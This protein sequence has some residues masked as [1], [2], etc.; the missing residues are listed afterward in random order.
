MN[1]LEP[2]IRR[3]IAAAICTMLV[4]TACSADSD[5]ADDDAVATSEDA[6]SDTAEETGDTESDPPGDA[7]EP[8]GDGGLITA[9]ECATRGEEGS[10]SLGEVT[11][12]GM[13][14]SVSAPMIAY[15]QE[16]GLL[17]AYGIDLEVVENTNPTTMYQEFVSGRYDVNLGDP[18]AHAAMAADGAPIRVLG[19]FNANLTW[20]VGTEDM[21]WTGPESLAGR[22]VAVLQGAGG[23]LLIRAALRQFHD[24]DIEEEAETVGA[25]SPPDA[26]SQVMAGA[27]DVGASFEVSISNAIVTNPEAGLVP[28][29][30]PNEDFAEFTDGETPWQ[31]VLSFRDD[32][33]A[34]ADTVQ[35]LFLAFQEAAE[36]LNDDV[37][38]LDRLA[39][40]HIGVEEGVYREAVESGRYVYDVRPMGEDIANDIRAMLEMRE[41]DDSYQGGEVPDSFYEGLTG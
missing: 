24:F 11:F 10:V 7:A 39:V 25:Q 1:L 21:E 20:L 15:A 16:N 8:D 33:G 17:D 22:R 2:N 14:R 18:I 27:A 13:Q 32:Q 19:G 5:T 34:D 36:A 35:C 28:V 26:L 3:L 9:E 4:L 40:E 12:G 41:A 29:Y 23:Y 38:L 6:P 37:D 30:N 31:T